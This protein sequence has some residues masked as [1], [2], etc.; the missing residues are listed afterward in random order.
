MT[1][2]FLIPT[3]NPLGIF[4][5]GYVYMTYPW[6]LGGVCMGMGR[7]WVMDDLVLLDMSCVGEG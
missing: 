3:L 6:E 2:T 5:W 1:R 4:L 7:V